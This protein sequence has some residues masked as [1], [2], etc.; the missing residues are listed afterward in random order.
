MGSLSQY[1]LTETLDVGPSHVIR[2]GL[3]NS[4]RRPVLVKLL[5][6]KHP[7]QRDIARLRHEYIITTEIDAPGILKPNVLF[8][9]GAG[10]AL[11]LEDFDGR[12]LDEI[13]R[14]GRLALPMALDIASCLAEAVAD[15]HAHRV[16]HKDIK[17]HNILVRTAPTCAVKL[18]EFGIATRLAQETRRVARLDALEGT[19]AYMS[20]EQTGRLN[21]PLDYRTDLY[22]LGVVLY[23]MF[24]GRLPFATKDPTEL[25]H[26][27]IARKPLALHER[28]EAIPEVISAIVAK[29]LA[30]PA[31]ER[32]QS[33][34][35]LKV[36]LDE[37]RERLRQTG[38]IASFSLGTK[39]APLG[40][41]AVQKLHGR[42]KERAAL[43]SAFQRAADGA[44]ELVLVKGPAGI[45]KSAL[46]NELHEV[47][48]RKGGY[49]VS[50]KFD[51]RA[52]N[53]PFTGISAALRELVRLLCV[54]PSERLAR[55]QSAI[56]EAAGANGKVLVDIVPEIERLIG[57]QPPVPD[58]GP[59]EAQN[60]AGLVFQNFLRVFTTR[61]HPL[62]LFLDDLQWADPAS[63]RLLSLLSTDPERCYL[64]IVGAYRDHEVGPGDPLSSTMAEVRN[65]G[66][67]FDEI[68]LRPLDLASARLFIADALGSSEEEVMPLARL[69]FEKTQGN[70]LFIAQLLRTLHDNGHITLDRE[71]CT[72]RFDVTRVE[73]TVAGDLVDF[74]A[75][76]IQRLEPLAQ[77]I[78]LLAACIG[79]RFDLRTLAAISEMSPA[80]T[81]AALSQPL[82]EGLV[83]PLDSGHEL[84]AEASSPDEA[85]PSVTY[86]FLHDR[87][88]QAAYSLMEEPRRR[89]I[90]LRIGRLLRDRSG[91][92]DREG[93]ILEIVDHLNLGAAGV[94]DRAER[95]EL[96]RANLLAGRRAKAA[97]AHQSAAA[98]LAAGMA[99][100]DD[101]SFDHDY[102]LAFALHAE[103]A[104]CEYLNGQ[105]QAAESLFDVLLAR[106]R[107]RLDRVRVYTL[108]VVL[109]TTRS[110]FAAAIRVGRAG[111]SLFGVELPETEEGFRAIFDAELVALKKNLAGRSI[112]DLEGAPELTDPEKRAHLE[113]LVKLRPSSF[114]SGAWLAAVIIVMPVNL[115]LT[116][117]RSELAEPIFSGIGYTL[118]SLRGMYDEARAFFR[119]S[120]GLAERS[121]ETRFRCNADVLRGGHAHFFEHFHAALPLLDRARRV[122]L[123]TG[124]FPFASYACYHSMMFRFCAGDT[125]PSLQEELDRSFTLVERTRNGFTKA[126]LVVGRQLVAALS[127]RTRSRTSLSD[128]DFDE[129]THLTTAKAQRFGF[130]VAFFHYAKALLALL[131]GDDR[132]VLAEAALSREAA[133]T[134]VFFSFAT[135]LVFYEGLALARLYASA[136]V[137]ERERYRVLLH[138]CQAKVEVWAKHCPQNYRHKELL[139]AAEIARID[140]HPLE[141]AD[142][143]RK[144]IEAAAEGEFFHHQALAN[145]LAAMLFIES[146]QTATGYLHLEEAHRCYLL[147][148]A[149]E[150]A[151]AIRAHYAEAYAPPRE[152]TSRPRSLPSSGIPSGGMDLIDSTAVVR[153]TQAIIAEID[154]ERLLDRLMRVMIANAG[155]DRGVL[156]LAR[157][158]KLWAEAAMTVDPDVVH[159][160]RESI[161]AGA[162]D[163]AETVVFYVERTREPIV[164]GDAR[165]PSRFSGDAYLAARPPKSM[166]CLAMVQKGSLA[167][168][169]Y[170][171][172]H[173]TPDAF[174]Q[175]RVELCTL[176]ATHAAIAVDNALLVEEL[177][178]RSAELS[179]SNRAMKDA[180]DALTAA[181]V[182]M[183]KTNEELARELVER[184][185]AEAARAAL[186][187]KLH[188]VQTPLIPITDSVMVMP[189][190][191]TI[192]AE[193]ALH[194]VETALQGASNSGA[195]VLILDITGVEQVD[196]GVSETLV[197]IA[198]AVKL[199]GAET[200]ITGMRPDVAQQLVAL[201]ID[202]TTLVTRGTLQTGITYAMQR[203]RG[204]GNALRGRG[205]W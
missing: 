55:F 58:L 41:R 24:A 8:R 66:A 90:H 42:D 95:F 19:L 26:S 82:Q 188:R 182:A 105:Y 205:A 22:S 73:A 4:D 107:S 118:I 170:L 23:E 189:I 86:R 33:A 155:A 109:H 75:A 194:L 119:L 136:T 135:D 102:E 193:R 71:S 130:S 77:R 52:R 185:Q 101:S 37:C 59:I 7:S 133:G 146:G 120:E 28:D 103:R 64:L 148:G 134:A 88:Q 131:Y 92:D 128:D 172:N 10:L 89:E 145:E 40:L 139:L 3:R 85:G 67:S 196:R 191:G 45:G 104:E 156:F 157:D 204:R 13:L 158:G 79:H 152:P 122:G 29:L 201:N 160:G 97:A 144:A 162:A 18:V 111:L 9:S 62:V 93:Q 202:L 96:A 137:H 140:G 56:R 125:L 168:I 78:L 108:L 35:G 46:V 180:F 186:A 68:E 70:P 15:I 72:L 184:K 106:A 198:N 16:I 21:R 129:A 6:D 76:K 163:V 57:P 200:V 153:A 69:V 192:D 81:A 171:E 147:W 47:I 116:Y 17:P 54:E 166:L 181:S 132:A 38:S 138:E 43:V 99:L 74:M 183:Q 124:D 167:G 65:Q 187:V 169:L 173:V 11:V 190:I 175:A 121:E 91:D 34:Y 141:A 114:L 83:L 25:V 12:P 44:A 61:E 31:E 177:R 143:Y 20:P 179:E 161:P 195:E 53:V 164:L 100:L 151:D 117:G 27:H 49:L 127:G 51:Q 60:R 63:L 203:R 174:T 113:L 14:K 80:E 48:A 98:Y 150:K 154:L 199:L 159:I 126:I 2:R 50:G 39:D 110:Q 176:V 32:Y 5:D 94:V 84:A 149:T 1:T 197:D 178:R 115:C 123:S 142:A 36:D 165:A 30:K 87:V 112:A